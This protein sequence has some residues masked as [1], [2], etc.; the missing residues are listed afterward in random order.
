MYSWDHQNS[1][2]DVP[3]FEPGR[4]MMVQPF[5]RW[6]IFGDKGRR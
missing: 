6:Q 3:G 4:G 5:E 2:Q 1:G